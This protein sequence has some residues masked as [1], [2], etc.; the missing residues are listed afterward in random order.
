MG[1]PPSQPPPNSLDSL[2]AVPLQGSAG[3][4]GRGQQAQWN[5]GGPRAGWQHIQSGLSPGQRP[6]EDVGAPLRSETSQGGSYNM[7]SRKPWQVAGWSRI[8]QH[9]ERESP[10]VEPTS[11]RRREGGPDG[12]G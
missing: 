4:P 1:P 2:E 6:V 9:E 3:G 5:A 11:K 7:R 12:L 8:R 10:D